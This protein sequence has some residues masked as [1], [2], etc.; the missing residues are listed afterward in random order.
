MVSFVR[1]INLFGAERTGTKPDFFSVRPLVA[2]ILVLNNGGKSSIPDSAVGR[3][4]R[5]RPWVWGRTA[6]TVKKGALVVRS[7]PGRR[8]GVCEKRYEKIGLDPS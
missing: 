5:A 4:E 7:Q 1:F 3:A 2:P 6:D 8:E